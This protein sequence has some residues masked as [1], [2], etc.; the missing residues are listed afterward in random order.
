MRAIPECLFGAAVALV[1][2]ECGTEMRK[3]KIN[4]HI[5]SRKCGG[6]CTLERAQEQEL[7]EHRPVTQGAQVSLQAWL[8][9]LQGCVNTEG[10]RACPVW[11]TQE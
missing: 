3:E 1:Q 6:S 11:R 2:A 5:V 8:R 4:I 10:S 7:V 9:G